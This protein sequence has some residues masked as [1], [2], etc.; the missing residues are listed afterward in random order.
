[1][2]IRLTTGWSLGPSVSGFWEPNCSTTMQ[3]T[4]SERVDLQASEQETDPAQKSP[5]CHGKTV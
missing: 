3:T 2:G 4:E 5:A 1:M